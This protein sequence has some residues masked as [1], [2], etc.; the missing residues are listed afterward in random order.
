MAYLE[1]DK[2][3]R[4]FL[5]SLDYEKVPNYW[6]ESQ[7]ALLNQGRYDIGIDFKKSVCSWIQLMIDFKMK[8]RNERGL[9]SSLP[10]SWLL[11]LK[12]YY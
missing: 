1:D 8:R 12:A 4:E 2:S 5:E 9:I 11:D 6:Q 7:T 3:E 10:D